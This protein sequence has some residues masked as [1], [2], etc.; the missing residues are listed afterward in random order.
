MN[1]QLSHALLEVSSRWRRIR[2]K[3]DNRLMNERRVLIV[4]GVCI[5]W[6]LLD[7]VWVTPSYQRLQKS[8]Q[9]QK[10]VLS[11]SAQAEAQSRSVLDT[12]RRQQQEAVSEL[13]RLKRRLFD[14]QSELE[15][16]QAQMAPARQMRDLL[17]A[18]LSR[19]ERLHLLSMNTLAPEEVRSPA[20]GDA[21]IY[22]HGLSLEI[23]GRFHDLLAWLQSAEQMPRRLIWDSIELVSDPQQ[24]L[25]LKVK[26]FTLSPDKEPLEIAP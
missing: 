25:V 7:S 11:S 4:A 22:R 14:Q 2:R 24:Q 1:H 26:V 12:L 9:K 5:T 8:L 16:V 3:F 23:G 10:Q 13:T 19:N 6:F 20:G 15:E 21:V 18:L 17:A